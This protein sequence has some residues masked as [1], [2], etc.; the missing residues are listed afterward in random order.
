[1]SLI[2]ASVETVSDGRVMDELEVVVS[3]GYICTMGQV[4][5]RGDTTEIV[6]VSITLW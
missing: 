6:K 2:R 5:I 4:S 3:P 1:M